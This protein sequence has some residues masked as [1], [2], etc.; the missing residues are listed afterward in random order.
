MYWW[1]GQIHK[2]EWEADET[3][4]AANTGK[5]NQPPQNLTLKPQIFLS[6]GLRL[7]IIT[8]LDYMFFGKHVW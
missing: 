3:E 4:K 6:F 5:N 7:N 2:P 1:D 8:F